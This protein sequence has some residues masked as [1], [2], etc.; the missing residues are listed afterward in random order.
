MR[1]CLSMSMLFK[2]ANYVFDAH[3]GLRYGHA[4][5]HLPPKEKGLLQLL[6]QARGQVVRKDELVSKVWSRSDASDESISRTVYRLRIAMQGAGG[7][8]VV[9]TVYNEGFRVNTPVH[10]SGT[11]STSSLT[12]TTQSARPCAIVAL[13]SAGEFSARHTPEDLD[14]AIAAARMAIALDPG[15]GAAWS[16]LAEIKV[17]AAI[18]SFRPPRECSWLA[19]EAARKALQLDPDSSAALAVRGWARVLIDSDCERGLTDLNRAIGSEPDYWPCNFFRGWALQAAGRHAEAIDMMRLALELN[20]IGPAVHAHIAL[21]LMYAGQ[22]DEALEVALELAHRFP[23]VDDAQ[24]IASIISSVHG[25]HADA[26]AFGQT[27]C[28]LSPDIPIV[29]TAL[30]AALAFAGRST[31]SRRELQRIE[32]SPLPVPSASIAAVYLALGDRNAAVHSLLDACQRGVPQFA[33]T[34]DDPRFAPLRGE[35]AVENAW[36]SIW[37]PSPTHG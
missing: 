6:L 30:A 16:R 11:L 26:I 25:R 4:T 36:A 20:P 14:A 1:L 12:A 22:H 28:Q 2:F 18:R 21:Q 15:F 29:R 19:K 7:P 31:Q 5:I 9:E 3:A 34:R 17:T 24:G 35:P 10:L 32:A 37:S 13:A 23:T 27:A 8:D 33:S